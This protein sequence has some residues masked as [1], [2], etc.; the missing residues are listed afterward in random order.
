M[1]GR[2]KKWLGIEGVKL[3]LVVAEENI[4]PG[5][6][7]GMV[8]L[9]SLQPQTVMAIKIVLIEKYTRGRGEERLVDEY[10]LGSVVLTEITE[11][12]PETIVE[13]PFSLPY[14]RLLSEVDEFGRRNPVFGGLAAAARWTRGV[15]SEYRLEAEAQVKGVALN[16]FDR[17]EIVLP[18]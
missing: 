8:R 6:V 9:M 12:P 4:V 18:K 13:R 7:E 15:K 5:R 10:Q 16:P 2:V 17:K 1:L 14:N 3:E 11:V